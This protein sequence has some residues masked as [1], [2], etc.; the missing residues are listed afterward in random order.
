MLDSCLTLEY[1]V[2][3]GKEIYGT[4]EVRWD[5]GTVLYMLHCLKLAA[6]A[7]TGIKVWTQDAYNADHSLYLY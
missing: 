1:H 6:S 4:A 5:Q 2:S 7:M 3:L